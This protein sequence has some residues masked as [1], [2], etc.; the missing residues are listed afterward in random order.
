MNMKKMIQQA[1]KM[2]EELNKTQ[3]ELDQTIFSSE[4]GGGAV[5]IEMNGK[6]EILDLS[7]DKEYI[8]PEDPEMLQDLIIVAVSD[9]IKKVE[10]TTQKEL[11]KHTKGIGGLF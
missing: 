10:E 7:I 3:K 5:K 1:K 11:G 2:Q 8:D 4:A 9:V 6:K